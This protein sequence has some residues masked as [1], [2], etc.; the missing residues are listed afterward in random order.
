MEVQDAQPSGPISVAANPARGTFTVRRFSGDASIVIGASLLAN[1]C[2]YIFHFVLSRR[3]GPEQYGTLATMIAI[4]S[5]LVV[6]GSSI[7]TVIMQETARMWV[8]HQDRKIPPFLRQA[9]SRIALLGVIVTLGLGVLSGLLRTYFHVAD[10]RLWWLL[11]VYGGLTAFTGFARGA[12]QGAHR[13]AIFGGSLVAEG[14]SKVIL[15]SAFVMI[16]FGVAGAIGGLISSVVIA[17]AIVFFPMAFGGERHI[18]QTDMPHLSGRTLKVL[19]AASAIS[20]LLYVDMLLAKHHFSAAQ[21]GFFGAAGTIARTIPYGAGLVML[22]LGP[23][24]AAAKHAG[25]SSLR[26]ILTLVSMSAAGAIVIGLLTVWLLP[27]VLI[28][29]TYGLAYAPAIPLLRLYAIDEALLAAAILGAM[30]LVAIG[31]YSVSICLLGAV[32][33]EATLMSALGS[34]PTRLLIIAIIVNACLAPAVWVLAVRSLHETSNA[35]G[36]RR[37]PP[38]QKTSLLSGFAAF[39][40]LTAR[41]ALHPSLVVRAIREHGIK[42]FAQKALQSS[43]TGF[44]RQLEYLSVAS[45]EHTPASIKRACSAFVEDVQE[46]DAA[47]LLIRLRGGERFLIRRAACDKDVWLLWETFCYASSLDAYDVRDKLVLDIGANLGDTAVYYGRR[48]AR[49]FAWE[50]STELASLAQ[51]NCDLNDV[52]AEV[53]NQGIGGCSGMF[54]LRSTGQAADWASTTVFPGLQTNQ[55]TT[56]AAGSEENVEIVPFGRVLDR[57]DDIYLAKINCEGCEYPALSSLTDAQLRKV[58]HYIVDCHADPNI[59]AER[60]TSAGYRVRLPEGSPLFAD[61]MK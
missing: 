53:N 24:A 3:L 61:R 14:I 36:E 60:F 28:Y 29:A 26:R 51:R 12:A 57:F 27:H 4:A 25:G 47:T 32:A 11:A 58:S 42:A 30:Y 19:S 5:I 13:F 33:L 22:I 52:H 35:K 7:G 44:A 21:A 39:V 17:I 43:R 54:V 41:V 55:R 15:G 18:A 16:G 6:I 38:L 34:T 8:T 56:F 31:E 1:A 2:S 49:V 46:N 9:G 45:M 20:A 10:A 37:R 48:G 40:R 50:P 59:I 23:L